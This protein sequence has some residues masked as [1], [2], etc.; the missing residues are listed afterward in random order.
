MMTL[1]ILSWVGLFTL[2]LLYKNNQAAVDEIVGSVN[3]QVNDIKDKVMSIIPI[4][5]SSKKEA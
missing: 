2:P 1:F 3:S 5:D 4:K